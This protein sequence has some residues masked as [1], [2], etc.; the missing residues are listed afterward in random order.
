MEIILCDSYA[1][2]GQRVTHIVRR[3]GI[4]NIITPVQGG[5]YVVALDN[6]GPV[7]RQA[8][9]W[10]AVTIDI[11]GIASI[12]RPYQHVAVPY[13]FC[14]RKPWHGWVYYE[15]YPQRQLRALSAFIDDIRRQGQSVTVTPIYKLLPERCDPHPQPELLKII[16]HAM[17]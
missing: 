2:H 17:I 11:Y 7:M 10:V 13:E 4:I 8:N 12:R 5:R 9:E 14:T 1:E 16:R 3:D 15:Y 6:V